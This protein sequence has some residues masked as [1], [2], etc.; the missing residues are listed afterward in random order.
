MAQTHTGENPPHANGSFLRL[1]GRIK[2]KNNRAGA[3]AMQSFLSHTNKIFIKANSAWSH[4]GTFQAWACFYNHLYNPKG[5]KK[6]VRCVALLRCT[7][8]GFTTE[9]TEA[10][11]NLWALP[12][13]G[14]H[15]SNSVSTMVPVT[16][17]GTHNSLDHQGIGTQVWL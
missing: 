7:L 1:T 15:G 11:G 2:R 3:Q 17:G 10:W 4:Y 9:R 12:W 8:P 14:R 13:A 6:E 5:E 16:S